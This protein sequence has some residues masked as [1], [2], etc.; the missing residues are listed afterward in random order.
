LRTRIPFSVLQEGLC[1]VHAAVAVPRVWR[2]LCAVKVK[3][4]IALGIG[5]ALDS[6]RPLQ[7]FAGFL[8][9]SREVDTQARQTVWSSRGKGGD[10]PGPGA[11]K[12]S[13]NEGGLSQSPPFVVFIDVFTTF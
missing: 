12:I 4:T 11:S 3:L 13:T 10:A 5:A 9:G 7:G 6:L 8:E 1:S 2:R